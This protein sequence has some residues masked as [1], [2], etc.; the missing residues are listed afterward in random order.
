MT[1]RSHQLAV[2]GFCLLALGLGG[3]LAPN[4]R[5]TDIGQVTARA[6]LRKGVASYYEI[7]ISRPTD[8]S[9]PRFSI[10]LPS[11]QII[12]RTSLTYDALKQVGFRDFHRDYQPQYSRELTGHG[13]SFHF[14]DD[15]LM[16]LRLGDVSRIGG[17]GVG[18]GRD[19]RKHFYLLP[20]SQ[21]DLEALFGHPNRMSNGHHW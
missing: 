2:L 9:A 4:L 12:Q 6:H 15:M 5:Y 14:S 17:D 19:D 8:A 18:I 3:C 7:E 11:G 1:S 10:Q 21:E 20:L 13:V 16:L